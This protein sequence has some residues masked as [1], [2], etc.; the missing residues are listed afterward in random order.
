MPWYSYHGLRTKSKKKLRTQKFYN[1]IKIFSRLQ[2]FFDSV[3]RP[4]AKYQGTTVYSNKWIS[5]R[6][7]IT[8]FQVYIQ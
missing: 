3:L 4:C 8:K 2:I 1:L 7:L 5:L 6:Y